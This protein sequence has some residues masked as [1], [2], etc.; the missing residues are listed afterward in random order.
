MKRSKPDNI[1]L[2]L[3]ACLTILISLSVQDATQ[4]ARLFDSPPRQP[5]PKPKPTP[6]PT[7]MP[8]TPAALTSDAK[9]YAATVGVDMDEAVR[10]LDLQDEI[11]ELNR[12][13]IEKESSTFAGLWIQHTPQFRVV[14][15]FAH[16]GEET[17]RPYVED[18]P[19]A[20]IVQVR[21]AEIPLVELEAIQAEALL[22]VRDLDVPV[23]SGINVFENRVELYVIE[24]VQFDTALQNARIQL[25][26]NVEVIT[27]NELSVDS[28][29]IYAGLALNTCTSGFSVA[30]SNGTKGI[31]TAAHC[32]NSQA[33]NGT[34]LPFEGSAYG[35][36]R[37][38]QWH[39]APGF[40]VKNWAHDG[41]QDNS[42]PYYRIIDATIHRN[43][44]ALNSFVCKYGK[45]T[46]YGCGYIIDKNYKPTTPGSWSSTFIRVHH[47]GVDLSEGGDSGGPWFLGDTAYGIMKSEIGDD[48]VYM[49]INY[50][51]IL[52]LT[53]LPVKIYLPLV[54][55][56]QN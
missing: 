42:T 1:V 22:K 38:V 25:P 43:N 16:N 37:D 18:G 54:L 5:T 10:R 46:G 8:Q 13:L 11:G 28:A 19:F 33:Y 27:V 2:F 34:S 53:V 14:V 23:E 51:D 12:R 35:G 32:S 50:V 17:I 48:A 29:N 9:A 49:A 56:G 26:D 44:Q 20:D 47:D 21:R 30:H 55:N 24:R 4:A 15:L 6:L 39:T 41:I 36:S 52:D 31:L 7:T 45:T 40:T 3:L